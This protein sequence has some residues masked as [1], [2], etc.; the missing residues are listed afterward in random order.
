MPLGS[1]GTCR[2]A[3]PL[4]VEVSGGWLEDAPVPEI[5]LVLHPVPV[6]VEMVTLLG[7]E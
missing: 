1:T 2:E 3:L 7:P 5:V 6:G 4:K